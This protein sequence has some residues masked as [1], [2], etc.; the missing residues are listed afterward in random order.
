MR[1]ILILLHFVLTTSFSFSQDI[2]PLW[3]SGAPGFEERKNEPEQ[4]KD[5][6]VKNIHN[7]SITV[8]LPPK[9]KATGAAVIVCPG[10][11]HREL[12]FD[13]EGSDAAKY[14]NSIGVAAFVLKYRLAY[15]ANSP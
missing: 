7:P 6:W 8:F 11:G 3:P 5:W 9:E 14:L 13:A 1:S 10:G 2:V 12:V 4:A 15:E